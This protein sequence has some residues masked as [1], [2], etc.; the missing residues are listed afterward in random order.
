VSNPPSPSTDDNDADDVADERRVCAV[1]GRI[2]NAYVSPEGERSWLHTF[3]DLPEDHPAVPVGLSDGIIALPRCDFCSAED[4]AW[5]LPARSFVIPG[6]TLG[7]VGNGS[8]GNWS[9]CATCAQL[10]DRNQWTALRRR[11]LAAWSDSTTGE[12][13][14]ADGEADVDRQLS[15]LYRLLRRNVTGPLRRCRP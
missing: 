12:D 4:P 7:P 6:L 13:T 9:A 2:L 10:I 1:C 14:G 3:A 15:Q 11:A 5:E 8:H